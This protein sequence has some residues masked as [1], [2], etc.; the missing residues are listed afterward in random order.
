METPVIRSPRAMPGWPVGCWMIRPSRLPSPGR[1]VIIMRWLFG[2][3][4]MFLAA[5][6]V[7]AADL[8]KKPN[9]VILLADDQG[10]ADTGFQG[11]KDINTPN[12]DALA[13]GGV[14]CTNGYVSGPYCSPTRAGL[15]TGRYQQRF[16]HEFNPGPT[17]EPG[18]G[19]A[20]TE[21]TLAQRLKDAGYTTG[22]VGKWHLGFEKQFHP[23]SRGF[24]SYF[25]FLGG[26]HPYFITKGQPPENP[27][28]RGFEPVDEKE[29]LTDAYAREASAFIDQH[30]KDKDP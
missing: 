16:G 10:Y 27:V 26:A 29:Y 1:E 2:M 30:S 20:L 28:M 11:C 7:W 23:L 3:A 6:G 15:M 5:G 8:A 18:F 24:Q 13:K 17:P 9:I 12:I 19:L 22:M 25:G 4:L 14:R 21:T